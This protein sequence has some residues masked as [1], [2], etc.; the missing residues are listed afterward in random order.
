MTMTHGV[1]S[2]AAAAVL[3]AGLLVG[4]LAAAAEP[5]TLRVIVVQTDNLKAYAHEVGALNALVRKAGVNAT[6][7]VFQARFAGHDAGAVVVSVEVPN[8][9][10]LAR[11]DEVLASDP[12]VSAQMAKVAAMRKIV[13]DS[14]YQEIGQ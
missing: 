2:I 10:A 12:G 13:S 7:R 11:M 9:A 4:T 1:K 8:L 6:I 3:G 5:A 14:L